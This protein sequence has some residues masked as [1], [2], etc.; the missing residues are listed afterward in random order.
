[1]Q[2]MLKSSLVGHLTLLQVVLSG[3]SSYSVVQGVVSKI[4]MLPKL[5]QLRLSFFVSPTP[6]TGPWPLF[7]SDNINIGQ[8]NSL[9]LEGSAM[10]A[11][12][13]TVS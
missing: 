3:R 1:M 8:L 9:V 7:F 4:H 2:Y 6:K 5:Q 11:I 13:L 10:P 12:A